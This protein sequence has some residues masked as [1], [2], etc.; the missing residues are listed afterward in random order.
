MTTLLALK[1]I[2]INVYRLLNVTIFEQ[3]L[4]D[5]CAIYEILERWKRDILKNL[6]VYIVIKIIVTIFKH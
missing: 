2:W 4:G 3:I 1:K 6:R 5:F